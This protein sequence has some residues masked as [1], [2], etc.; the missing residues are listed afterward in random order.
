MIK[1]YSRFVI[2]AY[3]LILS[4]CAGLTVDTIN[5]KLAVFEIAYSQT[6]ITIKIWI[7]EK[8]LTDSELQKIK[9]SIADVSTAR[10]AVYAAKQLG[11]LTQLDT[12]LAI[13][14]QSLLIL[15]DFIDKR[16]KPT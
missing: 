4:A 14:N 1:N 2:F 10:K 13:A 3:M 5:K 7:D 16:E 15:R 6:L 9:K 8:R 11:D 12:Q